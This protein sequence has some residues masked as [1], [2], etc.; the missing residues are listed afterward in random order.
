MKL[1]Y[2]VLELGSVLKPGTPPRILS[3]AWHR[4]AAATNILYVLVT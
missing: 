3:R 2:C 4:Y 1:I